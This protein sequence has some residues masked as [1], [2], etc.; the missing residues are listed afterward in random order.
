MSRFDL[1]EPNTAFALVVAIGFVAPLGD[2]AVSVIKRALRIKDMGVVL[3]GHGG[4]LDGIDA[5]L[6]A[7][8]AAG[9]VLRWGGLL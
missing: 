4:V 2:L 8:Q 7:F 1:W 5:T 9:V 6:F 3:T